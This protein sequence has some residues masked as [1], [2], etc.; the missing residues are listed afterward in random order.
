ML[1]GRRASLLATLEQAVPDCSHAPVI[2]ALRCCRGIDTLSAAGL[3]AEIGS[4]KRF[5]RPT[6]S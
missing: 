4:F 6:M 3:C 1:A 2:G 5:P